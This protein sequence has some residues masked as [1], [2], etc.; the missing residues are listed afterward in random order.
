[1]GEAAQSLGS[2]DQV[3]AAVRGRDVGLPSN[4]L[5]DDVTQKKPQGFATMDRKRQREVA[6]SGG[7]AAHA[8]GTAHEWSREQA[9]EASWKGVQARRRA[10]ATHDADPADALATPSPPVRGSA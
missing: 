1:M 7:R 10:A 6:R 4:K 3:I 9:R 5:E 8:K 2:Y